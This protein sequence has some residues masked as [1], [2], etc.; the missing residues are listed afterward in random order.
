[1]LICSLLH[2]T[3]RAQNIDDSNP[4]VTSLVDESKRLS[5][6]ADKLKFEAEVRALVEGNLACFG[7]GPCF[8]I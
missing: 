3:S 7:I 4:E 8:G 5:E 6:E 2:P 1:M